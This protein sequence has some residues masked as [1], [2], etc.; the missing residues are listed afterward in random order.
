MNYGKITVYI[1][2]DPPYKELGC[3]ADTDV[4]DVKLEFDSHVGRIDRNPENCIHF[5]YAADARYAGK[6]LMVKAFYSGALQTK[7]PNVASGLES[8]S[9]VNKI[10][11]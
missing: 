2:T 10:A 8:L 9:K 4:N 11:L 1:F 5:C 6:Q 3:F 7:L